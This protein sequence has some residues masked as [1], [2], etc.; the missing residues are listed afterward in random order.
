ME[1]RYRA[2]SEEYGLADIWQSPL[3]FRAL[4]HY[5]QIHN[6]A[7]SPLQITLNLIKI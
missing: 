7:H 5:L 1:L 3:H 4:S 2:N 6:K